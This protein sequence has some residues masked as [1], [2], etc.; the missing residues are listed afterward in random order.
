ML[1]VIGLVPLARDITNQL[2]KRS[3]SVYT[4][5][6]YGLNNFT[7]ASCTEK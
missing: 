3:S 1:I 6:N 5:E 4:K 2:H 7:I